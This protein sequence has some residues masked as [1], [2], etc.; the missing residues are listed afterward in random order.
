MLFSF[1]LKL[2]KTKPPGGTIKTI[3][4]EVLSA[5]HVV[6]PC[7]EEQQ[8]IASFWTAEDKRIALL[9]EKKAAL[10]QYKKDMMQKLFSQQIRIKDKEGKAFPDWEE[11]KLGEVG[12]IVTDLTYSPDDINQDGVLVLRSSK[13]QNR[14]ITFQDNVFV[15]TNKFNEVEINDI[16]MSPV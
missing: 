8:K 3:T 9:K 7:I 5:F 10:E 16:L 2:K 6:L 4:K 14:K 13:I 15:K 1:F 11:K 12:E